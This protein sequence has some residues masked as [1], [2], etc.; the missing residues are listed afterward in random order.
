[1]SA[2][3]SI[4]VW[5]ASS[6]SCL[7]TGHCWGKLCCRWQC[8]RELFRSTLLQPVSPNDI[9]S[10]T[11][12]LFFNSLEINLSVWRATSRFICGKRTRHSL[13]IPYSR[14]SHRVPSS[15]AGSHNSKWCPWWMCKKSD[16]EQQ[17]P[18]IFNYELYS[19]HGRSAVPWQVGSANHWV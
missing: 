8:I 7:K 5:S 15:T 11:A 19:K 1:M 12:G 2:N 9:S 18:I 16:Q 17:W 4:S 3:S 13:I 6:I 14:R 10:N